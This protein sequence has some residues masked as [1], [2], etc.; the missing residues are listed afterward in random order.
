MTSSRFGNTY[1]QCIIMRSKGSRTSKRHWH[2]S[3]IADD[4]SIWKFESKD[5]EYP[6]KWEMKLLDNAKY[7]D[8]TKEE[9][10]EPEKIDFYERF[11]TYEDWSV[12]AG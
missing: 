10:K 7:K 8:D 5:A 6:K 9:K 4:D 3:L 2:S 1:T 11:E 12:P